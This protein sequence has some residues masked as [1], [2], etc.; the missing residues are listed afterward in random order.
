[1]NQKGNDMKIIQ[2]RLSKSRQDILSVEFDFIRLV[3]HGICD[4]KKGIFNNASNK[5]VRQAIT[6]VHEAGAF[7]AISH[8]RRSVNALNSD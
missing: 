6:I 4:G 3:L 7:K 2:D 5:L 8:F 1:M